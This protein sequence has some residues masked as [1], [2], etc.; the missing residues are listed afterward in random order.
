MKKSILIISTGLSNGGLEKVSSLVANG[1]FRNNYEVYFIA[2]YSNEKK[3][4]LLEGVKYIFLDANY[5]NFVK[6]HITRSWKIIRLIRHI[7]PDVIISFINSELIAAQLLLRKKI[8]YSERTDPASLSVK[9]KALN[10]F[11]FSKS[12][13]VVFQTAGAQNFYSK[14]IQKKSVIIPNPISEDLPIWEENR[15]N[16]SIVTACR[17]NVNKNI[18]MLIRAFYEFSITHTEYSLEIYGKLEDKNYYNKLVQM[19]TKFKLIDKVHFHGFVSN[20]AEL[21]VKSE[22]FVLT[23]NYEG[24]SNSMLEALCMGIPTI[25]T[26]CPCG[27]AAAYI[28]DGHNGFLVGVNDSNQLAKK[29]AIVSDNHDKRTDLSHESQKLRKTLSEDRIINLWKKLIEFGVE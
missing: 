18:E 1:L 4:K 17:I 19:I 13:R 6:R 20:P 22:M 16:K 29:M 3:Y 5:K 15:H 27:G 8:I 11:L 14:R 25:C 23:S 10:K 28:K 12:Y 2:A 7:D 9:Y 24:L 26:D 21:E